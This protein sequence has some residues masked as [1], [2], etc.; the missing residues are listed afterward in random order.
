M[1]RILLIFTMLFLSVLVMGQGSDCNVATPFC[2]DGGSTFP[3]GIDNGSFQP[4]GNSYSCGFDVLFSQPNA[5]WYYLEIDMSGDLIVD[6]TSSPAEDID[7][8]AWGPYP[9]FASAQANC[10]SLPDAIDC[11]FDPQDNEILDIPG[12][13]SGQ[14]Y[15]VMITN[16]SNNPTNITVN[17]AS[18]NTASTN[19]DITTDCS[20]DPGTYSVSTTGSQSGNTITLCPGQ[21]FD[22]TS[23]LNY[24]LPIPQSG[25]SSELFYAIYDSA[26]PANPDPTVD[27]Q[28]SGLFWPDEDFLSSDPGG[29]NSNAE[30]GIPTSMTTSGVTGTGGTTVWFVPVTA[31]DS[32]NG[33]NPNG[34]IG[35]DQNGDN[36][37]EVGVPLQVI[38]LSA[39]E[40][41]TV[42]TCDPAT[43]NGSIEVTMSGGLP[44]Y[45]ISGNVGGSLSTTNIPNDG[46][47]VTISLTDGDSYGFNVTDANNCLNTFLGGTFNCN[48]SLGGNCE[49]TTVVAILDNNP[50][51]PASSIISNS[52]S[53]GTMGSGTEI[54]SVCLLIEHNWI[55]DL[56]I[57]LF[58]P[59]GS[60]VNLSSDNGGSSE[61]YGDVAG[62]IEVCFTP[63]A[64]NL[65]TTYTGGNIGDW[66]PEAGNFNAF[67]GSN[68]NGNWEL[69]ISDDE[70]LLSGSLISWSIEFS[71]G[72]CS[73]PCLTANED[74]N[75]AQIIN[76]TSGVT[77][78]SPGCTIGA[79]DDSAILD[80]SLCGDINGA[81][82]WYQF[83]TVEQI[84]YLD[85]SGDIPDPQIQFWTSCGNYL[86]NL[87]QIGSGGV[88]D[89]TLFP[90]SGDT[91]LI[92]VSSVSG[93]EGQFELC[94]LNE[95]D[96]SPCN[97]DN[98]LIES[99][100]SDPSTPIGGPYSAGETVEFCYTINDF[101]RAGCNWLHGIVPTWGECWT[102]PVGSQP[103]ITTALTTAGANM[104]A[105]VLSGT[106][107]TWSWFADGVVQYNNIPNGTLPAGTNVGGGWFFITTYDSDPENYNAA[108][109]NP[110]DPNQSYGDGYTSFPG[111]LDY[112][113]ENVFDNGYTWNV[114]F[115][116]TTQ[117]VSACSNSLLDCTVTVKTYGDGETGVWEDEG[118]YLDL[119]T[120]FSA[121]SCCVES[122]TATPVTECEGEV[123]VINSNYVGAG[124]VNWFSSPLGGT[125]IASGLSFTTPT[126]VGPGPV[127]YYLEVE[128]NGC[129]SER[130]SVIVTINEL[131]DISVINGNA[132]LCEGDASLINLSVSATAG[133]N[134]VWTATPG[135]PAGSGTQINVNPAVTTIYTIAATPING[136]P[137][138]EA[139]VVV[140]VE[141]CCETTP[142]L[143]GN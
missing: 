100:S 86:P 78:C 66:L 4:A 136:C 18:A 126:L 94:L 71:N 27:S 73:S 63:T 138:A 130:T 1:K 119:P 106:S 99:S 14:V 82:V 80:Q 21:S 133:S 141:D 91:Y 28:A 128:E 117:D 47:S 110:T 105:S 17:S 36:C 23:D 38:Y 122:V 2:T 42:I 81:A 22:I 32:D 95:P 39:V 75:S 15:L 132:I 116:L 85:L 72:N 44:P 124:T 142:G 74:C 123:A 79:S 113:C 59:N 139:V 30:G 88:I 11:S 57:E 62:G 69:S 70:L 127:T 25:E 98:D 107:G 96:P 16:Y 104:T 9:D 89:V 46:G 56:D 26:P 61:D 114:C 118:C 7:F 77:E 101:E 33:G 121:T 37:Y 40:Y 53:N 41:S 51:N 13:V 64:T 131:P 115:E 54:I 48:E 93:T 137:A 83:T 50:A 129:I 97:V 84:L 120:D 35:I 10:G 43:G 20:A 90:G 34:I 5:A 143:I 8:A 111:N 140:T 6:I 31:D 3:A 49:N 76:L 19:C 29:T 24:V 52:G 58:A 112:E 65:I 68:P 135:G 134:I 67:N 102:T 103:T 92:S 109:N 125:P 45:V 12:V 87:C 108:N 55:E 60:I